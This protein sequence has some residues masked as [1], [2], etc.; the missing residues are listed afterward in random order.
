[1]RDQTVRGS[2]SIQGSALAPNFAKY[3][4]AYANEPR[5]ASWTVIAGDVQMVDNGTLA[6]W[7]TRPISDSTYALRLQVF[8]ADN[9]ITGEF[10][11]GNVSISNT[12]TS[13]TTANSGATNSTASTT[14]ANSTTTSSGFDL[15][16][17]I[18]DAASGF[19]RGV[20]YVAYALIAFGVYLLIKKFVGGAIRAARKDRIDYG[21]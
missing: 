21:R 5:R 7:N 10:I 9:T 4:I 8:N 12:L 20:R 6:V 13:P 3:E 18:S 11:V 2:I 19:Q 16:K 14:T 1:V 17:I 15:G